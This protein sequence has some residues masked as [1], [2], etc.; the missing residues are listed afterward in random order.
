[1]VDEIVD[2]FR[3]I[4]IIDGRPGLPIRTREELVN[5]AW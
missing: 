5:P 4:R 2:P 1:M 3:M